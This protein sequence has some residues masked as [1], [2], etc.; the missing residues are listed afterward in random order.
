[1]TKKQDASW[2]GM[3]RME[4]SLIDEYIDPE[5]DYDE[6]DETFVGKASE[7][8]KRLWTY[9]SRTE[10]KATRTLIDAK[11]CKKGSEKDE[12]VK[13]AFEMKLKAEM[14]RSIL[15]LSLRDQFGIWNPTV[16]IGLRSGFQITTFKDT[17]NPLLDM[18]RGA[19]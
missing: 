4:L 3:L 6:K 13:H 18:L 19:L 16:G 10:E 7:E 8:V 9:Y 12:L 1:M 17:S 14:A 15:F 2:L 5:M 11:Y